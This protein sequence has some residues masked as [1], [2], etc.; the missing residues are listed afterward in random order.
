MSVAIIIAYSIIKSKQ[1]RLRPT[2]D[3]DRGAYDPLHAQLNA[4]DEGV[5]SFKSVTKWCSAKIY[6]TQTSM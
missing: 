3:T 5:H 1:I 4:D 2:E 6:L